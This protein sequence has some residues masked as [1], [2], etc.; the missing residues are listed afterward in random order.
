VPALSPSAG[1]TRSE[2]LL[3]KL[4]AL[5]EFERLTRPRCIDQQSIFIT[6]RTNSPNRTNAATR[7]PS[8]R[9]QILSGYI[10]PRFLRGGKKRSGEFLVKSEKMLDA[11][12]VALKRLRA[13]AEVHG[14][15]EGSAMRA[16]S[17]TIT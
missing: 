2:S 11:L 4:Y 6:F 7:A 5:S 8:A 10:F 12:A 17:E 3:L 1:A 9:D 16:K 15:V 14:A 13:I